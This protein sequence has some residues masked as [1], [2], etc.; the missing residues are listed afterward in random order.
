MPHGVLQ[1]LLLGPSPSSLTRAAPDSRCAPPRAGIGSE[2]R[3][4]RAR[5]SGGGGGRHVTDHTAL[6]LHALQLASCLR[7]AVW[8]QAKKMHVCTCVGGCLPD[9]IVGDLQQEQCSVSE[10]AVSTAHNIP[11]AGWA[12]RDA[13]SCCNA[14]NHSTPASIRPAC[15]SRALWKQ[16]LP[17]STHPSGSP[18]AHPLIHAPTH[19][20]TSNLTLMGGSRPCASSS[21]ATEGKPNLQRSRNSRPPGKFLIFQTRASFSGAYVAEPWVGARG[22][23]PGG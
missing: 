20:P 1:Q 12:H 19:P 3:C 9:A 14:T 4:S 13:D 22:K 16:P 17:T 5:G 11:R 10:R 7:S 21:A 2:Y 15:H 8:L 6:H 18:P 23:W